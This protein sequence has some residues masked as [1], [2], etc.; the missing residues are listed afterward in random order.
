M[1]IA[2]ICAPIVV[3]ALITG[4]C[5]LPLAYGL[6]LVA[7]LWKRQHPRARMAAIAAATLWLLIVP[8]VAYVLLSS[9]W[10]HALRL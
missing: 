7:D 5:G 6:L 9:G 4:F 3:V 1:E 8:T 2:I 10:Q